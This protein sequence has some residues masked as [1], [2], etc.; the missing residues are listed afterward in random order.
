MS[1]ISK[2]IDS[3][4]YLSFEECSRTISENIDLQSYDLFMAKRGPEK[5]YRSNILTEVQKNALIEL[6]KN[7]SL[8]KRC[9]LKTHMLF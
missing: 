2:A 7:E 6:I 8:V 4:G 3:M 5:I 1:R 9:K